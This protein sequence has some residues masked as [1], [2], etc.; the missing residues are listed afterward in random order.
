[1]HERVYVQYP[2]Q[3]QGEI[4][5]RPL[6]LTRTDGIVHGR[7]LVEK[8]EADNPQTENVVVHASHCG[9]GVNPSVMVVLADRLH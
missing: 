5:P 9:L 1:V 4:V 6:D 7:G 2:V 8:P 3:S